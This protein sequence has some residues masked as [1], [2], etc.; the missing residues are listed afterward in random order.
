M[1]DVTMDIIKNIKHEID[2]IYKFVPDGPSKQV[3]IERFCEGVL[4]LKETDR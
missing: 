1:T 3:A 2:K 4:W